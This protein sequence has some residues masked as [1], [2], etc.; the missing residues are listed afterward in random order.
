MSKPNKKPVPKAKKP[1]DK[2]GRAPLQAKPL[3][4]TFYWSALGFII[5]IT[6]LIR[7]RLLNIPFERDEGEYAYIA[8]S[9]LKGIAPFKE[10][11]TMKLPGTSAMYAFL[12]EIFG[13]TNKGVH[14][15][16]LLVG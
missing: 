4:D 2:A 13:Q 14:L 8:K 6:S 9:I 12:M 5:F 7:F 15:G 10:T 1:S 16:L 11:Y 3:G